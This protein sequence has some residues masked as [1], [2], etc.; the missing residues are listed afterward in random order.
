[1]KWHDAR[2]RRLIETHHGATPAYW[3]RKWSSA[4]VAVYDAA[5]VRPYIATTRRWLPPQSRLLEGGCGNGGKM[6]ALLDAGY[7]VTGIDYAEATVARLQS[8]RPGWDVRVG[9]VF[10]LD[11]PDASYDGYWSFGVIE[12]FW[13]GYQGLLAEAGRV[14]RPGGMLFLTFPA[15]SPLRRTKA[16]LRLYRP[17]PVAD[18]TGAAATAA[19]ADFYQFMLDP[20]TVCA[21]LRTAGFVPE[22]PTLIQASHGLKNE[23][24]RLWRALRLAGRVLSVDARTRLEAGLEQ[25]LAAQ[26]GHLCLLAA[27][28][29]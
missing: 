28:K 9:D 15:L 26:L 29:A 16:A 12:H 17:W 14:L 2:G 4:P 25:R 11:Q 23:T 3:D 8:A 19:P 5:A 27:R 18:G 20:Q 10:R 1:M 6:A 22:T 24:P 21:Q 7:Q 13:D